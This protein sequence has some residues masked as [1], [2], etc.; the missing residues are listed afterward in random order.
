M[1][2]IVNHSHFLILVGKLRF[3][4]FFSYFGTFANKVAQT[5]FVLH[6]TLHTTLFGIYYCVEVVRIVNHSHIFNITW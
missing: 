4:G 2:R 6:K 3:S 5:W 1:V